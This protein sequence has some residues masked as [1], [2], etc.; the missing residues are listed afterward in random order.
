MTCTDTNVM[1]VVRA[2]LLVEQSPSTHINIDLVNY[3]YM[4]IRRID[5]DV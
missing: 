4:Q 5:V 1:R 3:R 2:V